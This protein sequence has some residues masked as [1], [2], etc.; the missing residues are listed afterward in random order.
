MDFPC[1]TRF[2]DYE[3]VSP[4]GGGGMGQVYLATELKLGRS[5][6]VK[7][8]REELAE[9]RDALK[10]F[11]QEARSVSALNHP[12]IVTIHAIGMLGSLPY[13]AMG[14]VEG[15]TLRDVLHEGPLPT[16]QV[17][18]FARQ[19]VSGLAKAHAAGVIHR[20]LKPENLMLTPDGFIKIV[21]FGLAKLL[22]DLGSS[23]A[24]TVRTEFRTASGVILGTVNYASPEQV[25]G[26]AVDARSDQFALGTILYEMITG[27]LAFSHA[28]LVQ[29]LSMVIE[30]E[31]EAIDHLRPDCPPKLRA[32]VE[33]LMSKQAA[34]R[35]SSTMELAEKLQS[36]QLSDS[37]LPSLRAMAIPTIRSLAVLPLENLNQ[38]AEEEYFTDG[39]TEALIT[40]LA[41]IGSL[42]VISRSSAMRYKG[43]DKS[44]HQ[45]ASELSVDVLLEGSVLRAGE[46]VRISVQLIE[47]RTEQHLWAESYER[48]RRDILSL[49]SEVARKVAE[50]ILVKLTPLEDE[51]LTRVRQ[52]HLSAHELYLK[53]R[54]CGNRRSIAGLEEA[55]SL[56][57]LALAADPHYALAYAG[58]A[59][60][61]NTLGL[62]VLAPP[63]DVMPKAKA[64]AMK[65]LEYD[66][67]LAEAHTALASVHLLY[68]WNWDKAEKELERA[69]ELNPS[70][71]QAHLSRAMLL[72]AL[73]RLPEGMA[74]IRQTL[75]LDPLS[76]AISNGVSWYLLMLRR[77]D[78]ALE[79][80]D[81]TLELEADSFQ[82]H[83]CRCL[84]Y[85][86]KKMYA[87]SIA[88]L[89]SSLSIRKAERVAG[90]VQRVY[91]RSG[92][93]A[94]LV[95]AAQIAAWSSYRFALARFAR[96]RSSGYASRI[97]VAILYAV[98]GESKGAVRW[99][100]KAH[101]E[102][103]PQLVFL[104]V[105]P[106]WDEIRSHP[107]FAAL[108]ERVGLPA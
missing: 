68:E 19:T 94:S 71:A 20:D 36:F 32:I 10:R 30:R 33:R 51:L 107:E 56:F 14:L 59:H 102:R 21:D 39:M 49:Q 38:A 5:V 16:E 17:L 60:S 70:S 34:D 87:E 46:R 85:A 73:N 18:I 101:G 12:N 3:I 76:A 44:L 69:L 80:C 4:L 100:K 23:D 62:S 86:R 103:D 93:E 91:D 47:A 52:V 54:Y 63:V 42:R 11:E 53:G 77:Y 22:P 89:K 9:D 58:L 72:G 90:V 37:P 61:Y 78:D 55:V 28:T 105:S 79:Q 48:D 8:L 97:G 67:T 84:A 92:F 66:D 74:A 43:S 82:A 50:Q 27:Q 25:S 95:K 26:A 106:F 7:F 96:V 88:A 29:T 81:K 2:D 104:K 108:V 83:A 40:D 15:R 6:A 65:A 45:I 24:R 1:G 99:L 13:I 31:P 57:Q 75:S 98:A 64:A 41:K 35:F